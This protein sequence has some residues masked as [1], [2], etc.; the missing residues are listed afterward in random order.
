ML[1]NNN[2]V[3]IQFLHSSFWTLFQGLEILTHYRTRL[4]KTSDK[5]LAQSNGCIK[6]Y[7]C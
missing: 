6:N 7:S 5:I 3:L 2:K 4:L 1:E